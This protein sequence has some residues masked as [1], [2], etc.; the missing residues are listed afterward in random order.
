M[1]RA[2]WTV[3]VQFVLTAT[4]IYHA[5]VLDLPPWAVKAIDKILR[6][7]MWRGCKEAKGGHCLITWPKVTRPKSLRGLGISNIKNLNRAL[8]ARWL[9]LRKSEPSKPWASLPIQAS[10]CV[11]ALCSMAVATEVGN[12]TNT[13]F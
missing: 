9:W 1:T 11:Q 8:R 2:G 7:Y 13:L 4:T 12:G 3:Q 6:S 10:E 5:V